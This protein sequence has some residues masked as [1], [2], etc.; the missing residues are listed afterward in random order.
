MPLTIRPAMAIPGVSSPTVLSVD[1]RAELAAGGE[2]GAVG[3]ALKLPEMPADG[4]S[5]SSVSRNLFL[6]TF[7]NT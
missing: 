7:V 3:E 5:V 1:A 4:W 6:L 2:S